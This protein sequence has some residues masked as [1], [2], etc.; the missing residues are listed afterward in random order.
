MSKNL[1]EIVVGELFEGQDVAV[2]VLVIGASDAMI[3]I[4]GMNGHV[5][6]LICNLSH[7][8]TAV[9]VG[10]VNGGI[11]ARMLNLGDFSNVRATGIV[12]SMIIGVCDGRDIPGSRIVTYRSGVPLK[13]SVTLQKLRGRTTSDIG[14]RGVIVA[15]NV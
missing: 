9:G 7:V 5:A 1:P 2:P 12:G 4:A 6:A 13:I 8:V 15:Q 3:S 11:V 14:A 10:V